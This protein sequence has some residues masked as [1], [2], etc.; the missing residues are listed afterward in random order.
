VVCRVTVGDSGGDPEPTAD[1]LRAGVDPDGEPSLEEVETMMFAGMVGA[2][3][4]K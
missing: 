3:D 4:N 2:L 1:E